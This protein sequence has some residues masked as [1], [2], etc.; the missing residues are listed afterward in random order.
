MHAQALPPRRRSSSGGRTVSAERDA[1]AGKRSPRRLDGGHGQRTTDPLDNRR[2]NYRDARGRI[3]TVVE[4]LDGR[5][6]TTRYG[7]DALDQV[8]RV[9]DAAGNLTSASYDLA[10]SLEAIEHVENDEAFVREARRVLRASGIF[11]CSTPNRMLTNPGTTVLERPFNRHHV[12][13][14]RRDELKSLLRRHFDGVEVLSQSSYAAA[15]ERALALVGR[16]SPWLAARLHQARKVASI[17]FES[18]ARH[19]PEPV[20]AG[21]VPEVLLAICRATS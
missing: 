6:I 14:Y 21:R 2:D 5:G 11:L 3:R 4:Y 16:F 10:V 17:P 15:Y 19:R 18:R 12:R 9:T 7:Y 1:P 8:R 13:E 20:R